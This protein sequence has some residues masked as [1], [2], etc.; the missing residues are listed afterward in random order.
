MSGPPTATDR[1]IRGV[2]EQL[3][4][5]ETRYRLL[6]GVVG[7]VVS[8]AVGTSGFN[9]MLGPLNLGVLE[10]IW[11]ALLA[12]GGAAGLL[13]SVV[14]LAPALLAIAS[15]RL[16]DDGTAATP[17]DDS[18]ESLKRRY[19]EG[20]VDDEEFEQRLDRL[21]R[22]PDSDEGSARAETEQTT[23]QRDRQKAYDK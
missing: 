10:F 14:V 19:A 9:F 12:V 17:D 23:A 1:Q 18:V 13:T 15:G 16:A 21:L 20:E 22:S 5:D 6:L 8:I 4:P 3:L 2:L 11:G 7:T